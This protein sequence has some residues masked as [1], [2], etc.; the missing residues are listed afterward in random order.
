MPR[1]RAP[2]GPLELAPA[3]DLG[4]SRVLVGTC[5][6]TDSTLVNE[7]DWYPRRSMT[8]DERLAFYASRFPVVEAD[9]TYYFPPTPDMFASL[10]PCI[11]EYSPMN[12]KA[13]STL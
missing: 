6:W 1:R 7:T 8:A 9:S 12:V 3:I 5:S 4:G 10:S 11:P 13:S 2:D